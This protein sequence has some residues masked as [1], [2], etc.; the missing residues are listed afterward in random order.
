MHEPVPVPG[1]IG[2]GGPG[3]SY[4]L[5]WPLGSSVFMLLAAWLIRRD[6]R[7]FDRLRLRAKP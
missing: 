3:S 2:D 7:L 5:W 6:R 4:A 1:A